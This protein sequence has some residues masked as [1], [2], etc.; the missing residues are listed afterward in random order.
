MN[1][2]YIAFSSA[3]VALCF[4]MAG[5]PN[6]I[7]RIIYKRDPRDPFR[8]QRIKPFDCEFCLAFWI[9]IISA[10]YFEK[11]MVEI[12]YIGSMASLLALVIDKLLI[13]LFD[14]R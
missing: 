11:S 10:I 12:I 8:P 5:I 6:R 9:G 2:I 1:N 13:K 14:W 4:I 7:K 3:C